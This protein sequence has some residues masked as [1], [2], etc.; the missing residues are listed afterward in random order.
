MSLFMSVAEHR[1]FIAENLP[2]LRAL[3]IIRHHADIRSQFFKRN[4]DMLYAV[5]GTGGFSLYIYKKKHGHIV[6]NFE[7]HHGGYT[8]RLA[9]ARGTRLDEVLAQLTEKLTDPAK[10]EKEDAPLQ[11][12]RSKKE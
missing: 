10:Q 6:I 12:S 9:R 1:A 4:R 11:R 7:R 3:A 2:V 5:Y 8:T